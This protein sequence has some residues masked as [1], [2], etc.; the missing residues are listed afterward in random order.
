VEQAL[1]ERAD[2]VV[3]GGGAIGC[4]VALHLAEAGVQRVVL[5]EA[6]ELGAGSTSKGAGG[7]RSSF[8][9]SANLAM[10]LRG[11]DVYSRFAELFGQQIDF[12]PRG[13]LYCLTDAETVEAFAECSDLQRRHGIPSR[14]IS[15][16][17]A[18]SLSP[19][20]STQG[21]LGAMWSQ[22]DA[23]CAPDSV[24]IGY[25][26]AARRA[27][28]KLITQTP[29]TD[30]VSSGGAI[31][32][33]RTT[34]GEIRTR[35]AVCAAGAWS[36]AIG[37]MV[38]EAL[39]VAPLRRQIAYT[40]SVVSLAR[41]SPMTIDFPSTFYFHPEGQRLLFGWSDPDEPEGF[42]THFKLE[43]WIEKVAERAAIRVPRLLDLG[44][45]GGWA[46]LYEVTPDHNQIIGRSTLVEGFYY[47]AGFSGHGFQ[48]A[49]AT[50]EIIRDL[51]L[52]RDPS[53]SV[54]EFDVARFR[55]GVAADSE[56]NII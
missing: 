31:A 26:G 47:A 55:T 40:E 22:N 42:E 46:G 24:T 43:G 45:A 36:A 18:Q 37:D 15:P 51:F 23:I 14:M 3:I 50:G 52:G 34:R 5:L 48:M 53:Y 19:M 20:I 30:V 12:V 44:V 35:A 11:L 2:V 6:G 8:S 1:P 32:A 41:D 21:M 39:P 9:T 33:V 25:A 4:S 27:G 7:V 49:P 13:Y 56:R 10:G 16:D 54:D 29:A 17:E 38:G 28:A